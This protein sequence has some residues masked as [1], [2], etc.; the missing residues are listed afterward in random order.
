MFGGTWLVFPRPWACGSTLGISLEQSFIQI[1]ANGS[2][3]P[4]S[5]DAATYTKVSKCCEAIILKLSLRPPS[6]KLD[7]LSPW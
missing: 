3:E 1:A 7:C 5:Q 6:D 2:L 4:N